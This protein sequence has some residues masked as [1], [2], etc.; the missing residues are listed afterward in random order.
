MFVRGCARLHRAMKVS[1]VGPPDF[2]CCMQRRPSLRPRKL[3]LVVL[4]LL[5]RLISYSSP[6]MSLSFFQLL[7]PPFHFF[8]RIELITVTALLISRCIASGS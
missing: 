7:P 8:S 2:L 4:F 6:S 1:S 5:L 3:S